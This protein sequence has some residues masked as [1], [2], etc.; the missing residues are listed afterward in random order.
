MYEDFSLCHTWAGDASVYSTSSARKTW[1]N[2][3]SN[4]IICLVY[5]DQRPLLI[6]AEDVES[7]ALATLIV[8][9]LRGGVKVCIAVAVCPYIMLL[10]FGGWVYVHL[11][12]CCYRFSTD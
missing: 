5:Q 11:C 8:N 10:A 6:V 12:V 1:I 3:I 2:F 4:H 9:K 7:E